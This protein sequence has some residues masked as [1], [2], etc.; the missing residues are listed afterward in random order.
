MSDA[1]DDATAPAGVADTV[2]GFQRRMWRAQRIAWVVMATVIVAAAMGAFG[3][4]PLSATE[5]R[6]ASGATTIAYHRVVRAQAPFDLELRAA[7][8]TGD[9]ITVAVAPSLA[10]HFDAVRLVPDADTEIAAGDAMLWRV[11]TV[12]G[13]PVRIRLTAEVRTVGL[14]RGAVR[15]GADDGVPVTL[16]VLP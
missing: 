14:L 5:R 7:G 16:L 6:S 4:G 2:T 1:G 9:R 10:R 3:D 13:G 12:R 11:A 8:T 15:L